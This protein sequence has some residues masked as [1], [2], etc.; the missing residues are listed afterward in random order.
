[1]QALLNVWEIMNGY[2]FCKLAGVISYLRA[3]EVLA[4]KDGDGEVWPKQIHNHHRPHLEEARRQCELI[5]LSGS[6]HR[7]DLFLRVL[8]PGLRWFALKNQAK[9]LLEEIEGELHKRRF[10]FVAM[11][12]ATIHDNVSKDWADVWVKIP[13]SKEDIERAIDCYVL[14]QDTASVF[15]LMRV[16]EVGLR[17]LAKKLRVR[18]IHNGKTCPIEYGDWEKVITGIK[19]KIEQTRTLPAGPK[20]QAKL[21]FYSDAADHCVFMKDIWRNNVSHTRR[22]Y[23]DS[24]ALAVLS[25]VKGFMDFLG[26]HI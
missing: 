14:E 11:A 8:K 23:N 26:T 4:G 1:V 16:A 19:N 13:L 9:V 22:A 5:E 17:A 6:V 3:T 12:K 21:E 15:H 20:K 2:D 10:V 18:I 24:E 7:C 25:R